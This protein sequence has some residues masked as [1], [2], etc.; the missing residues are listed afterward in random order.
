[1]LISHHLCPYVQRAVISLTEKGVDFDRRYVDLAK[2]P[3]WFLALTPLAKT[4][5]LKIGKSVIFESAVIMEYLEETQPNRLHPDDPVLRADHR[6]WIEFGS[7]ILSTIW[8]LYSAPNDET[9]KAKA[10]VLASRFQQIETR[11]SASPYFDGPAFSLVDAAFGPVFRYFDVFDQI[12][13]F[14]ILSNKPKVAA[15]R[16]AL[17]ERPSVRTAV[18]HD[19][20]ARLRRFLEARN[21]RLSH[22]MTV[23][24]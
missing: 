5:V 9:M 13:D 14:S 18:S 3:D 8:A 22:L 1:M 20:N 19:Y 17:A 15:W 4:P 11:L 7:G 10:T 23:A 6:A 21:S 24:A 12:A 16:K 2:K